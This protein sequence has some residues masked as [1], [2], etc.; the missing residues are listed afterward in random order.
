MNWVEAFRIQLVFF[1]MIT[2]H[3]LVRR[4]IMPD[5]KHM[6]AGIMVYVGVLWF[7]VGLWARWYFQ[8]PL[9]GIWGYL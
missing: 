6:S 4:I 7:T 8:W 1:I 3:N 5:A 9:W 2:S